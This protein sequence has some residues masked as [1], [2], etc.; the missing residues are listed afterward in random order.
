[1]KFIKV[2]LEVLDD[3]FITK[4][5]NSKKVIALTKSLPKERTYS[6]FFYHNETCESPGVRIYTSNI[7]RINN[8][9]RFYDGDN[10]PF[11]IKILD[12]NF[13]IN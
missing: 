5:T 8:E 10:R 7:E 2:E 13:D 6:L 4:R 1:M 12:E 9:I 3:D 11:K